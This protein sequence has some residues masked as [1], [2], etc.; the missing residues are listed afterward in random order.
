VTGDEFFRTITEEILGYVLHEMTDLAG[1][2]CS[3]LDADG[4]DQMVQTH[5][6]FRP[7]QPECSATHI[8][9]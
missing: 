5:L 4:E 1:G 6:R 9:R 2:F 3:T 7:S 8:E